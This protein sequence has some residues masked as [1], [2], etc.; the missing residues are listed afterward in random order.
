MNEIVI[1][2][3][4]GGTG[5]TSIAASFAAI[6]ESKVLADCD[7]DASDLHL[8]LFPTVVDKGEFWSGKKARIEEEKCN[9]CGLCQELCRFNAIK[10]FKVDHLSCEGCGFCFHACPAG[11]IVMEDVLSGHWFVSE[12]RYG[13]LVHARLIPGEENSGKLVALVRQKAKA[14]AEEK[15]LK[16]IITD[17]PPGIGCPV[18]SSLSGAAMALLVAEPTMSGVSDLERA[19]GVCNHFGIPAAV[20]INKYDLNEEIGREIERYCSQRGIE[21]IGKLPFDEAFVEAISKG[22]PVVEYSK[23]SIR[24]EIERIWETI[25]TRVKKQ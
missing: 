4:K 24:N 9:E 13:P 15:A 17:G 14:L 19:V 10:N 18:I 25:A 6:G 1:I 16:Y 11:A 5:K 12:T 7:V 8:V 22:V 23:G 3:G 20:C 2:S 21:L